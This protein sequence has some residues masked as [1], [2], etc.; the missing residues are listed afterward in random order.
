M[1]EIIDLLYI[2]D[3]NFEYFA[4]NKSIEAEFNYSLVIFKDL[5]DTNTHTIFEYGEKLNYD[6]YTEATL[7]E[8][9][10]KVTEKINEYKGI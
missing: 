7:E 5:N 3:I 9:L 2:N 10:N 8:V 6:K 4:H 1:K